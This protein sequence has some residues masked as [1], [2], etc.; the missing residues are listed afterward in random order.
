MLRCW[1][2]QRRFFRNDSVS[3]VES[4]LRRV[5]RGERASCWFGI[6]LDVVM[7]MGFERAEDSGMG[8]GCAGA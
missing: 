2:S 7:M 5:V 4:M 8:A 3:S 1:R 6:V